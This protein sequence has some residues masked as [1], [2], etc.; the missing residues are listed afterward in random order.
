[1][2]NHFPG[3]EWPTMLTPFRDGKVDYPAL[4]ELIEWYI[5]HKVSGLF[6]VCQSSEMFFLSKEERVTCIKGIKTLYGSANDPYDRELLK[7]A[8]SSLDY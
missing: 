1:M 8:I 6:A 2:T 4:A 5:A 7:L 3:G